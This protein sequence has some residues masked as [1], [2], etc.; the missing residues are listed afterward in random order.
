MIFRHIEAVLQKINP[1]VARAVGRDF[2]ED[3][4]ESEARAHVGVE[5]VGSRGVLAAIPHLIEVDKALDN[6]LFTPNLI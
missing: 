6:S 2:S 1:N 4:V 5:G 3:D